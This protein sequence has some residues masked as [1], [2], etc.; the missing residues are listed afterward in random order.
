MNG[1]DLFRGFPVGIDGPGDCNILCSLSTQGQW[2]K[3]NQDK[4]GYEALWDHR[5]TL[6]TK[7]KAARVSCCISCEGEKTMLRRWL[8]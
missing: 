1:K 5:Q 4:G 6:V 2:V 7:V 8:S 3:S